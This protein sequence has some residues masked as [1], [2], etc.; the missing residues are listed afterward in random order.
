MIYDISQPIHAGTA[1]W[2]GD[3]PY[4]LSHALR[5]ANGASVNLTTLTLSPHT[6]THA[7]AYFHFQQTGTFTDAM[8]LDAYI[9]RAHV[10]TVAKTDGALTREDFA[11]GILEVGQR[12]L[13][14]S[15]TSPQ[16]ER[17][18]PSRF[19]YLSVDLIA[20]FA[21]HGGRLIG[22]ESPSVDEV[23]SK[24][25]PC[26]HALAAHRLVNLENLVLHGVPDG[27]YE[28]IALPLKL[29]GACASPVRAILRPWKD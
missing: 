22:L 23:T 5:I 1:V 7:D 19:V 20:Y 2:D 18:F 10:V 6:G 25:L 12:L 15:A 27:T 21:A 13:I 29:A 26:H 9:G 4:T 11:E 24:T 3:Q 8:P 14:R 28:L 16:D 17:V